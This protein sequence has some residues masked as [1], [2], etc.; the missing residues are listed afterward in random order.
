MSSSS[1]YRCSS[2]TVQKLETYCPLSVTFFPQPAG[3][4][5]FCA[6]TAALKGA[7]IPSPFPGE[8][9]N[10]SPGHDLYVSTINQVTEYAQRDAALELDRLEISFVELS[11]TIH[12]EVQTLLDLSG[13]SVH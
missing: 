9:V 13:L 7:I 5:I 10:F 12:D 6:S 11:K 1:T 8:K 3:R 4:L 2:R